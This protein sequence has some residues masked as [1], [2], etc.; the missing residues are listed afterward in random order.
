MVFA[1]VDVSNTH[2]GILQEYWDSL[3]DYEPSEREEEL[4]HQICTEIGPEVLLQRSMLFQKLLDGIRSSNPKRFR[5]NVDAIRVWLR[6]IRKKVYEM[7]FS[8][9]DVGGDSDS[10]GGMETFVLKQER[11]L[12]LFEAAHYVFVALCGVLQVRQAIIWAMEL[13]DEIFDYVIMYTTKHKNEEIVF[14]YV[15]ELLSA[16]RSDI[17]HDRMLVQYVLAL[18]FR[19]LVKLGPLCRDCRKLYYQS[20]LLMVQQDRLIEVSERVIDGIK[21]HF[22]VLHYMLCFA[23]KQTL[24]VVL[25][26]LV[27][28]QQHS[29]RLEH[30][31][32]VG[33]VSGIHSESYKLKEYWLSLIQTE[34]LLDDPFWKVHNVHLQGLEGW[35]EESL[36]D[37]W[38][39]KQ[40]DLEKMWFFF[41]GLLHRNESYRHSCVLK[42]QKWVP[43]DSLSKN[44]FRISPSSLSSSEFVKGTFVPLKSIL[45]DLQSK[46]TSITLLK[47][48]LY[49]LHRGH[50]EPI[51]L[52]QSA[53]FLVP[54]L[55]DANIDM[56]RWILVLDAIIKMG[57]QSNSLIQPLLE[58][59][60]VFK[61][62]LLRIGC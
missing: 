4:L 53:T 44:A 1:I 24:N 34:E 42:L 60:D 17:M 50:W 52:Q 62:I 38:I 32:V 10:I 19:V 16:V 30:M 43:C 8:F 23:G 59:V 58:D 5:R 27:P 6:S 46:N 2:N 45:K 14:K 33:D 29:K 7:A 56:E 3:G 15:D 61:A 55:K 9:G 12:D 37:V 57:Y 40:T 41:R 51:Q 49:H 11:V 54:L 48:L 47:N 31:L 39:Q 18:V 36:C 25:E 26:H 28:V 20:M 35:M 21:E 22:E 13:F